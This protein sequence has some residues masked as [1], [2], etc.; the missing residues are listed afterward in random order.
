GREEPLIARYADLN[1]V[2]DRV[3]EALHGP[4]GATAG[5]N[6]GEN[7]SLMAI[8]RNYSRP[9]LLA[10]GVICIMLAFVGKLSAL[11]ATIPVFV[12][13][14]LALYLF[15]GIGLQGIALMPG[16]NGKLFHPP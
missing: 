2:L 6:Y 3:R 5:T 1:V 12:S 15:G 10:A 13:G 9:A 8:T 7:N 16:D 4:L 11:A 14:G